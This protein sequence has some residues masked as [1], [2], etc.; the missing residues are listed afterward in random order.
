MDLRETGW[1]SIEWMKLAQDGDRWRA[2]VN[3]MMNLRVLAP[4]SQIGSR[5][6]RTPMKW[7]AIVESLRNTVLSGLPTW[8]FPTKTLYTFLISPMRATCPAHLML[9]FIVLSLRSYIAT[10][11]KVYERKTQSTVQQPTTHYKKQ[12]IKVSLHYKQNIPIQ[13]CNMLFWNVI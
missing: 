8:S 2:L 10:R 1:E 5:V 12:Q 9:I 3:T 6:R 4:W 7:S 11:F 13:H